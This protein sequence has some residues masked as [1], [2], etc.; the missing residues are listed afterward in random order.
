[1][2]LTD[3]SKKQTD[4]WLQGVKTTNVDDLFRKARA[5]GI[6]EMEVNK[7]ELLIIATFLAA[8]SCDFLG[9]TGKRN[10]NVLKS[11]HIFDGIKEEDIDAFK[12]LQE[13]KATKFYGISLKEI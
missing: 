2:I 10:Q 13:G 4:S 9:H 12:F 1:M 3:Y 6:T 11:H 7:E 5:E 8:N